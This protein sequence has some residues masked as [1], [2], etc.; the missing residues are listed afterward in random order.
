VRV[1]KAMADISRHCAMIT[2]LGSYPVA[3]GK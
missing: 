3:A 1:K 2:V